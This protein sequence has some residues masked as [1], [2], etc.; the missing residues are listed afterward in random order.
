M[1]NYKTQL[2]ED[3][4][5]VVRIVVE[6]LSKSSHEEETRLIA[7]CQNDSPDDYELAKMFENM[8]TV[9]L[10]ASYD[11][12]ST[13]DKLLVAK[14]SINTHLQV[15]SGEIAPFGKI[16]RYELEDKSQIY[17]AFDLDGEYMSVF[18]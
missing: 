5:R 12:L 8:K 9:V 1:K 10:G 13:H 3:I 15:T 6:A 17:R 14:A 11:E 2:E 16:L 7:I 4:E 18:S